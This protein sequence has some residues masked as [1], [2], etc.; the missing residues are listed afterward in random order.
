M[1][2]RLHGVKPCLLTTARIAQRF[3]IIA[4]IAV[5]WFTTAETATANKER[6]FLSTKFTQKH[7]E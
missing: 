7:L 4:L 6:M 5:I 2:K 3:E 1:S